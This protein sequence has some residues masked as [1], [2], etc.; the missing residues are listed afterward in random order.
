MDGSMDRVQVRS[1]E[2]LKR[3]HVLE[4]RRQLPGRQERVTLLLENLD[5]SLDT[6]AT[7]LGPV[8]R[9]L[10]DSAAPGL[11]LE[12]PQTELATFL[13][14]VTARLDRA[15]ASVRELTDRVDL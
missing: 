7:V 5:Q 1:D 13:A 10:Q 14:A 12:E 2:D 4:Q 9:P 8:L 6:L 3:L 11:A 15:V